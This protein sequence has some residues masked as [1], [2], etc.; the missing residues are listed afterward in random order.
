MITKNETC[1]TRAQYVLQN[2]KRS[3]LVK[4]HWTMFFFQWIHFYKLHVI[5]AIKA[6]WW[7]YRRRIQLPLKER[8]SLYEWN[9]WK[10]YKAHHHYIMKRKKHLWLISGSILTSELRQHYA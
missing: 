4:Y 2:V 9:S 1:E 8:F 5:S 10:K 6:D 3:V 7:A